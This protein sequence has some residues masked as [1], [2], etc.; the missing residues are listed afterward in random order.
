MPSISLPTGSYALVEP[1]AS[2]RRLINCFAETSPTISSEDSK[3]KDTPVILRRAP[4]V[5]AFCDLSNGLSINGQVR[6]LEMMQGLL[7]AVIGQNLYSVN[8]AGTPTLLGSSIVGSGRVHMANNKYCLVIVIPNSNSGYT[9]DLGSNTLLPITAST[10]LSLGALNVGFIDSYIVFL[11]KNGLGFYNSD[12]QVVSGTGPISFTSTL[13]GQFIRQFGSD[14][15]VGMDI[16]HRT[17][18]MFGQLTSEAFIDAGNTAGTPFS[19]APNNFMEM[20]CINGETVA[21]QDQSTF[22]VANDRTVRRLTGVTPTRV[23]NHG[24]ENVLEE[25]YMGDAYAFCYTLGGH[26]MYALT[27]PTAGRTL[28]Y[29]CTTTEWHEMSSLIGLLG[30]SAVGVHSNDAAA[31]L[32]YW[33]PLCSINAYGMQ[34]VGDSQYPIIGQLSTDVFS[35]LGMPLEAMWIH[36]AIYDNHNRLRH[37]RL[38]LVIG[39]GNTYVAPTGQATYPQITLKISDNGGNTYRTMPTRSLGLQ[40]HRKD[41]V[42]WYNL[43]MS[44][45]RVYQ[46]NMS[47]P[48][49]M[50]VTDAQAEVTEVPH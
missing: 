45:D 23:S 12:S 10:F 29:D 15:F 21:K 9:Y 48:Y 43:G 32:G 44:R 5:V 37:K 20:G 41:R 6:G 33:R 36:Q 28:V 1:R 39:T 3:D 27:L 46:F 24:I 34:L 14:P 13:S 35:E 11:Q 31:A 26:L 2:S 8:S 19:S 25:I 30:H 42:V 18:N 38:E 50:W 22:W 40:G 4:G 16:D 49:E 47:D 7:Y 17:I